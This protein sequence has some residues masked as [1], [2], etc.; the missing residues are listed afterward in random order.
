MKKTILLTLFC[1]GLL[2][3]VWKNTRPI[4]SQSNSVDIEFS[5]ER[6]GSLFQIPGMGLSTPITA[7]TAQEVK[8]IYGTDMYI[9]LTNP[10]VTDVTSQSFETLSS[11]FYWY[12]LFTQNNTI[13]AVLDAYQLHNNTSRLIVE[14]EQV[15]A[16]FIQSLKTQYPG[17][18]VHA[19]NLPIWPRSR[20]NEIYSIVQPPLIEGI[21]FW[22]A[23]INTGSVFGDIKLTFDTFF[24][25]SKGI[26]SDEVTHPADS[27]LAVSDV[28][29]TAN[30]GAAKTAYLSGTI[31]SAVISSV[32][33]M[34][35]TG[36]APIKYII[37]GMF[38]DLSSAEKI[39]TAHYARF[40]VGAP[41]I[42]WPHAISNNGN[43][44][45]NAFL[46]DSNTKPIVGV[47]G[48]YPQGFYGFLTNTENAPVTVDFGSRVDFTT[49]TAVS[50]LTNQGVTPS[51]G[52][53]VLNSYDTIVFYPNN[54]PGITPPAGG[55]TITSGQATPTTV[56]GQPT[57][58]MRVIS[59]NAQQLLGDFDC[60]LVVDETDFTRWKES[61]ATGSPLSLFEYW[62]RVFLQ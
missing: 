24:D 61:F 41:S 48:K 1:I 21:S 18:E 49:H 27:I 31:A 60:S 30:S 52:Q 34:G 36:E 51:N 5:D 16:A 19:G 40:V 17:I 8:N 39:L 28:R 23:N 35:R 38:N 13:T 22:M 9:K 37:P 2:V 47:I 62:R 29:Y 53:M 44:W 6:Y 3:L 50:I 12:F 55:V 42:V 26:A 56:P 54:F 32:Q 11:S 25:A 7:Q 45:D 59:C 4:S 57:P 43:P 15:D 10:T 20:V 46:S 58:T 14:L 33:S